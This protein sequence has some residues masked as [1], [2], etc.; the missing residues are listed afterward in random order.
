MCGI[1]WSQAQAAGALLGT[2]TVLNEFI[3]YV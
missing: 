2:K 3:A 1:P